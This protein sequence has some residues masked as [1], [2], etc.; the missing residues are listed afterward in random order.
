M[1]RRRGGGKIG[2]VDQRGGVARVGRGE[3]KGR[4]GG[5]GGGGWS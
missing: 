4:G 5:G 1:G 2:R 3:K